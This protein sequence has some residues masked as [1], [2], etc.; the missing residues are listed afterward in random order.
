MNSAELARR[1]T[2]AA[3]SGLCATRAAMSLT[4]AE[5]P[6]SSSSTPLTTVEGADRRSAASA[7][8][9]AVTR[10]AVPSAISVV[11][12]VTGSSYCTRGA[13]AAPRP[14]R[15]RSA[16]T[17]TGSNSEPERRSSSL[18]TS[19]GASRTPPQRPDRR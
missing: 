1:S 3:I 10:V 17:A 9:R 2:W 14:T 11:G 7:T 16:A 6:S 4:G 8:T 13:S 5:P 15:A 12:T 19:A 18:I